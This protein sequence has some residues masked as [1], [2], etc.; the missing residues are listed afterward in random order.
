MTKS[1]V[2]SPWQGKL[3]L[4][5]AQRN[6]KTQI[7]DQFS[8]APWKIQRPFYPEGSKICHCVAVHTA[9]GMVGGD[10]LMAEWE[11]QPQ[12]QVLMT[13]PTASKIYRSNGA[14]TQ[15]L[16]NLKLGNSAFLE[17]LPQESII[18]D[19]ANYQQKLQ[20]DLAP[21]AIWFG[22][23]INRFGRSARGEKFLQGHWQSHTEIW[24]AGL[25][26]WIDRQQLPAHMSLSSNG[27]AG[28]PVAATLALV[29]RK[30]EAEVLDQIRGLT[31]LNSSTC[32][33]GVSRLIEGLICRYRGDST[34]AVRQWFIDIW[35]ILR[36]LYLQRQIC[37]PRVWQ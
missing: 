4:K 29:G 30:I 33:F 18:F 22:W 14:T 36:P 27:L 21:N 10:R 20:V 13:T 35:Q 31:T 37:S 9:G 32:S 8:Q 28:Y 2:F 34:Q 7:I 1:D 3:A 17:W 15:Q 19:G 5:F 6:N 24:R 16:I 26:L 11:L 12:T 25:P 23:E